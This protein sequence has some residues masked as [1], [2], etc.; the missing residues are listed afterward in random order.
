MIGFIIIIYIVSFIFKK[1]KVTVKRNY[2]ELKFLMISLTSAV[3]VLS[4]TFNLTTVLGISISIFSIFMIFKINNYIF[5][6]EL[7]KIYF[8]LIILCLMITNVIAV[9]LL[10][11]MYFHLD[12]FN[13]R[14]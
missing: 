6:E 12:Q 7:Q 8:V 9:M 3:I 10:I 2:S 1:N 14:I 13:L 11:S 5:I 4:D